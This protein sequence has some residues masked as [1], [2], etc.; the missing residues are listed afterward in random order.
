MSGRMPFKLLI[1]YEEALRL[2]FEYTTSIA[3]IKLANL[4]EL[5]GRVLAEEIIADA[6]VPPFNRSAMDGYAVKAEDTFGASSSIPKVL[7]LTGILHAGELPRM[8]LE[9][10]KC[11]QIATGSQ[12]P[13]GADAVVM[14]EYT[15]KIGEEVHVLK[16]AYPGANVSL[17]GEDVKKGEVVLGKGDFLTPAKIGVL[18]ALGKKEARVYQKPKAA[19]VPTG[20]EIQEV[21]SELK[22]GKIYDV[23]SHTLSSVLVRNG[24]DVTR[25]KAVSDSLDELKNLIE[26]LD[27]YDMIVFSG[28]SSVGERDLLVRVIEEMG[29]VLFHGVQIKPGKPTLFGLVKE[30]IIFGMPGY[31]TSCLSN[32]YLLLIPAV[33]KM[34]RLPRKPERRVKVRMSRRIVSSSGRKQF[35]TVKVREGRAF[36]AFKESSAI[37]SMSEA[38]GYIVLPE[39][40]DVLE[41]GEEVEVILLD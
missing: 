19:V 23:N 9:N 17:K 13:V 18:A 27:N 6:F 2:V 28:G 14:T 36:P 10:G 33:R 24:A 40:L 1:S 26:R 12:I 34:A 32:A 25:F 39:N 37:T 30:K 11:V 35:L 5:T 29:K 20:T 16:P 31:P 7:K 21:G 4:E 3:R 41:E 15:E 8:E 38:D 22:E